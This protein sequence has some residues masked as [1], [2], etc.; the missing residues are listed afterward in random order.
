MSHRGTCTRCRKSKPVTVTGL[1]RVHNA[2]GRPCRGGAQLP[3]EAAVQAVRAV[4]GDL[5]VLDVDG[6]DVVRLDD[7]TAAVALAAARFGVEA[8][9]G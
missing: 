5:P 8:G 2:A 6:A 7:L 1:I 9:D 4:L 3:A